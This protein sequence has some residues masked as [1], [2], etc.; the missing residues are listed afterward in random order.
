MIREKQI[1]DFSGIEWSLVNCPPK[2]LKFYEAEIAVEDPSSIPAA[3]KKLIEQATLLGLEVLN[4][5]QMR[6]FIFWLDREV[7]VEIEL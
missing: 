3:R 1:F 2:N 7:N 4:N 5:E 6:E